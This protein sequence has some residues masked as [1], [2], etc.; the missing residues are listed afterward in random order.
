MSGE[1]KVDLRIQKTKAAIRK[2]FEEMICEMDYEQITVKELAKKAQIN[3]KTFYLHYST[4]NDL[5]QELQDEMAQQFLQRIQ[6]MNCPE[7]MDK[8]TREF[9]LSS[10]ELGKLGEVLNCCSSYRGISRGITNNI[11]KQAW[12]KGEANIGYED[13]MQNMIMAYVSEG[14]LEMYRCWVSDGRKVPLDDV[15]NM[16]TQLVCSGVNGI[17]D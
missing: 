3:R 6:G 5:L 17:T 13:N 4:L 15:I 11:M 9:F 12:Q 8:I 14:T 16:A 10:E 2:A 1:Y 7:D